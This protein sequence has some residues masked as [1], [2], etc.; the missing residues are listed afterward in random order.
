MPTL[1]FLQLMSSLYLYPALCCS[2]QI[3]TQNLTQHPTDLQLDVWA[4]RKKKGYEL[5]N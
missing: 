5:N 4:M 3:L 1:Q 2:L